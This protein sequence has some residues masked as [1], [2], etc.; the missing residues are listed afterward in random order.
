MPRDTNFT[1]AYNAIPG[2]MRVA[3]YSASSIEAANGNVGYG[4]L[5]IYR[6]LYSSKSN[7]FSIISFN[8]GYNASTFEQIAS[9]NTHS[10]IK[11]IRHTIDIN[12]N[13][14]YIELYIEAIDSNNRLSISM[15]CNIDGNNNITWKPTEG[16]STE[17]TVEGVT[18][19]SSLD[20]TS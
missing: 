19:V 18:V 15:P 8:A 13:T 9:N 7:E 2:W 20:L 10:L 5:I 17:E 12:T 3:K 4:G 1:K 6:T 16:E 11:K 14:A